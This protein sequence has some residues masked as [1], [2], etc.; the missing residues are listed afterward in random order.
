[1][2]YSLLSGYREGRLFIWVLDEK[3]AKL[4]THLHLVPRLRMT[5]LA[6]IY[7]VVF[8]GLMMEGH[9]KNKQ[10]GFLTASYNAPKMAPTSKQWITIFITKLLDWRCLEK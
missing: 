5:P 10:L 3:G 4:T 8:W 2:N 6:F 9:D 7:E 1:M